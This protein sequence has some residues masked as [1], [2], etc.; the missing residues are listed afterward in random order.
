MMK[1]YVFSILL[2]CLTLVPVTG[3]GGSAYYRDTTLVQAADEDDLDY[4]FQKARS[5]AALG[6][7]Q[8]AIL[9]Y[10]EILK[11]DSRNETAYIEV[12]EIAFRIGN[13]AYSNALMSKLVALNPEDLESRKV[14]MEV[15][16]TFEVYTEE[17]KIVFE[18]LQ[19]N[20][21]D[22]V[23]LDRLATLY[24]TF[25]LHA[26]RAKVL[27]YLIELKPQNRAYYLQLADLY[28][29]HLDKA[30][31]GLHTYERYL[32][33][34]PEDVDLLS[35]LAFKYGEADY[36]GKQINCYERIHELAIDT[37]YWHEA[38]FRSYWQALR[39]YDLRFNVREA[40]DQC[41]SFMEQ[42]GERDDLRALY[43]GL[44]S[45]AKPLINY[46]TA[47]RGFDFAGRTT[48][49][50][51]ILSIGFLGPFTG[52]SITV[53]NNYLYIKQDYE[54][55]IPGEYEPGLLESQLYQGRVMFDQRFS[56]LSMHVDAGLHQPISGLSDT[57]THFISTAKINYKPFENYA[58]SASYNLSTLTDNPIAIDQQIRQQQ[59]FLGM[60]YSF[61]EDFRVSARYL[62]GYLSDNNTHSNA[63]IRLEYNIIQTL[64]RSDD[65]EARHPLGYNYTGM[66]MSAGIQYSYLDYAWESY[67]Y[68]TVL[69]EHQA[70]VFVLLEKQFVQ[71]FVGRVEAFTGMNNYQNLMWGYNLT[72]EKNISWRLNL[73]L[74][75]DHFLSPY[76]IGNT[77]Y[78][79]SESTI[80]L[81]IISRF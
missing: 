47:L 60:E 32:E 24:G 34:H 21:S 66:Q 5:L 20:P 64:F 33:L 77:H 9:T 22:T 46:K 58:V 56:N 70:S 40:R 35:L 6:K 68:P 76:T 74:Q 3:Q 71:S 41:E 81:G 1:F 79:N 72:L 78:T 55:F 48:H 36:Y 51:N 17:M 8:A 52:S 13:W 25:D 73:F 43:G 7:E 26:E 62:R 39:N 80:Q 59:I 14:M 61:L 65:I 4:L 53:E 18:L 37:V 49:L 44:A 11:I 2:I 28:S 12:G 54:P 38:L 29:H 45:A 30:D 27:E 69:N 23:L 75:W 57:R 50:K 10:Q 42:K 19:L 15:Y 31:K 67:V 63:N 16:R